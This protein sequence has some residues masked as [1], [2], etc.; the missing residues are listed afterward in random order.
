MELCEGGDLFSKHP[1][2][3]TTVCLII[4]QILSALVYLHDRNIV[5][6]DIKCENI[7]FVTDSKEDYTVKII[8]FGL[9]KKYQYRWNVMYERVGT[10]R[11]TEHI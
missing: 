4:K 1:Y 7:M 6:R 3:E 9:A 2:S 5:H 11:K 8:D 10:V